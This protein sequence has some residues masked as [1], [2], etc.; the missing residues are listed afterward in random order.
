MGPRV[1]STKKPPFP[2]EVEDVASIQSLSVLS[3]LGKNWDVSERNLGS[4]DKQASPTD[5]SDRADHGD[6]GELPLSV[7]YS[8][9]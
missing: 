4:I 1:L 5:P 7:D 3:N 6:R 2:G 8:K 9:V